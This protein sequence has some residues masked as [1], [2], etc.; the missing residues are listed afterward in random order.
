L[1]NIRNAAL[2]RATKGGLIALFV[3]VNYQLVNGVLMLLKLTQ[4]HDASV[5]Q[6]N[7]M[8]VL[9]TAIFVLHTARKPSSLKFQ[10]YLRAVRS[11]AE[12]QAK[13]HK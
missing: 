13:R 12:D 4:P 1:K 2:P 7:A 5:H 11:I 9:A 10:A 3:L 6:L 8:L